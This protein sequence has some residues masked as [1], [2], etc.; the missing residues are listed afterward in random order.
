MQPYEHSHLPINAPS[1][2]KHLIA[3]DVDEIIGNS[4]FSSLE[5]PADART[6]YCNYEDPVDQPRALDQFL[7]KAV[8]DALKRPIDVDTMVQR[9]R[10]LSQEPSASLITLGS[11]NTGKVLERALSPA[12]IRKIEL[13][14]LDHTHSAF[15][16]SNDSSAIAITG[17]SRKFPGANNPEELWS[18]LEQGI[19]THQEVFNTTILLM[20]C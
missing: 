16:L 10:S 20:P 1:H 14:D 17:M 15:S 12:S 4:P 3:L 8:A 6:V 7:R 18:L 11:V 2:A 13:E 9:I 19:D 5:V